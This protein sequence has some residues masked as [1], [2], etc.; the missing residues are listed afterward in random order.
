MGDGEVLGALKRR[1]CFFGEFGMGMG[2]M[3]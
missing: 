2:Y 1:R 3:K